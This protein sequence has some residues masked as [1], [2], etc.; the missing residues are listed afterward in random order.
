MIIANI[1]IPPQWTPIQ[2]KSLIDSVGTAIPDI[3]D[4]ILI[5][6]GDF[7]FAFDDLALGEDGSTI[8]TGNY[9]SVGIQEHWHQTFPDITE[10]FQ[11]LPACKSGDC[12]SSL[13]RCYMRVFTAFLLDLIPELALSWTHA[14]N[15]ATFQTMSQYI[16]QLV[17]YV[18]TG[19]ISYPNGSPPPLSIL[20]FVRRL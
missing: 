17:L 15:N 18:L 7:N 2:K 1:H 16:S 9:E 19:R 4:A 6:L 11:D 5:A 12:L 20:L 14:H 13:D 3:S 8:G 10:I